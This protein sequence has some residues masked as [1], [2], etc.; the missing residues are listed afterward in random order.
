MARSVKI[1]KSREEQE[2]HFLSYFFE[3]TPSERLQ[4][5]ERLRMK[6]R[7]SQPD[8]THRKVTLKKHF[9]YGH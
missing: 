2:L 6:N 9:I 1:F 7:P 8:V 5:L 4:A 3:L